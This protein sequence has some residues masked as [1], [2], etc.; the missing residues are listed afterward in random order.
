MKR[1][2]YEQE[3]YLEWM[4]QHLGTTDLKEAAQQIISRRDGLSGSKRAGDLRRLRLRMCYA[5][6]MNMAVYGAVLEIIPYTATLQLEV[7]ETEM[8]IL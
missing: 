1:T 4:Q 8:E 2:A 5:L 7:Y 6:V 3:K